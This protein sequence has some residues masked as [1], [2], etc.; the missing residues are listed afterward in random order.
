LRPILRALNPVHMKNIS[1]K[2]LEM[3]CQLNNAVEKISYLLSMEPWA[4][5][6]KALS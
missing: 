3:S 1:H 5:A 2:V 4:A 6:K